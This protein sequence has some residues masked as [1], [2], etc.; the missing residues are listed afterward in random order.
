MSE[1]YVGIDVSKDTLD[2]AVRPGGQTWSTTNDL[3]GIDELVPRL[4]AMAP[5]LIVMEATGGLELPVGSQLAIAGLAVAIVNPRQ[6]R[7]F[8]R[9]TGRLAK[10]D[11]LDAQVLAHFAEAMQPEPRPLPD[12][13]RLVLDDLVARRRQMVE[14]LTAERNRL[15]RARRVVRPRIEA[16]IQWL[17]KELESLD[18]DLEAFIHQSPLWRE[19]ENLLQSVP[20]V[21]PVVARTLLAHLPELGK[22]NRKEIAAL[23]GVAPLNRDSGHYRGRRTIWGG[24]ASVRSAL[25]MSA[26][27]ATRYNP[28]IAEVYQRLLAAGKEKKVAL[29]ACM[30]K[31]LV[32]LNA[33]VKT[34]QHWNSGILSKSASA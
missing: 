18:D 8:A 7:D 11:S 16:H 6:V 33:M 10:T 30:R 20:G 19:Q 3:E 4:V 12:P 2:V 1:I 14:M 34:G 23:V 32:I 31:L 5:V 24:R 28:V 26:L 9:A 22:L 17:Q 29:V 15:H 27:V 21:G 25:Y 13:D